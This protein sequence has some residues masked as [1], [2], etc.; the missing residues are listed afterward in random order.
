MLKQLAQSPNRRDRLAV[1]EALNAINT[2]NAS[3]LL[4]QMARSETDEQ[5]RCEA[6]LAL[7][8]QRVKEAIPLLADLVQK[9]EPSIASTAAIGLTRYG[10]EGRK[11]L[12]RLLNSERRETRLAAA[13]ALATLSDPLAIETLKQQANTNDLAQRVTVL[14]LMARA[15]DERA[16]RELISFLSHDEPVVRLRARLSI[17]AVGKHAIPLLLQTLDSPDSRLRAES[18]LILGALKA[19]VA[20][21]KIASLLRDPDPQVREAAQMAL[22]RLEEPNQ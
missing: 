2:P 19:D 8:N 14:Q 22:S 20:R 18:A 16:L 9:G 11:V 21:E 10:E 5:I 15:G 13:K 7:S 6:L 3:K 4:L 12:R 17:Y 1:V